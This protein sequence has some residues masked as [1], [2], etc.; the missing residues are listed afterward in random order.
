[1][2]KISRKDNESWK[3]CALRYG[4]K[5]GMDEEVLEEYEKLKAQG[6]TDR[7][8]AFYACVECDICDWDNGGP[9][10]S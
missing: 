10:E 6:M 2:L 8:A 3:E 9:N 7:E 5:Y 1:M 4:Y